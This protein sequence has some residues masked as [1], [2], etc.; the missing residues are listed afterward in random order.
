[1]IKI[2]LLN[3]PQNQAAQDKAQGESASAPAKVKAPRSRSAG[4]ASKGACL[5]IVGILVFL[6][7]AAAGGGYYYWIDRSLKAQRQLNASL[8]DEKKLLEP[9]VGEAERVGAQYA[10]Q[11][12]KEEAL[13]RVKKQQQLPVYFWTELEHSVPEKVFLLR[14]TQKGQKVEIKGESLTEDAIFQFRDALDSRSQWF[15]HVN[16]GGQ[17]RRGSVMEFGISLDLVNP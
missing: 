16:L 12:K 6:L 11:S 3:E 2:N 17:M 8:T 7:F 9:F 13:L 1:M 14:L 15:S 5:P 10:V 4:A